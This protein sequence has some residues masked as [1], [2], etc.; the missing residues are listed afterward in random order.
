MCSGYTRALSS[1]LYHAGFKNSLKGAGYFLGAATVAVSPTLALSILVGLIVLAMPWAAFGLDSQL[2][3]AKGK[4]V[5]LQDVFKMQYNI[6]L[7][8]AAR[9][10]LFGARCA[11]RP[12]RTCAQA[13]VSLPDPLYARF[14]RRRSS[15]SEC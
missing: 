11:L 5:T 10:F 3:R 2:G 13:P 7:L 6:N 14:A 15:V 1:L 12:V 4:P 9:I 8:S